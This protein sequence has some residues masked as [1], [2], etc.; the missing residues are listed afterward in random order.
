MGQGV[1]SVEAYRPW[2]L[3]LFPAPVHETPI[4]PEGRYRI[5][6]GVPYL[7]YEVTGAWCTLIHCHGNATDCEHV[8]AKCRALAGQLGVNVVSWEYP[9]YGCRAGETPTAERMRQDAVAVY[10]HLVDHLG[11][12]PQHILVLGH[13]IGS[14]PAV[15]LA[16]SRPS[17]GGLILISPYTSIAA[18]VAHKLGWPWAYVLP[19]IFDNARHAAQVSCPV[20]L[21][22]G[23]AD[24]LIPSHHSETLATLFVR[25]ELRVVEDATHNAWHWTRDIIVPV[26]K[27]LQTLYKDI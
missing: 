2:R 16:A 14:G 22:H 5:A 18:I 17:L 24:T 23:G 12:L 3:F 27:W 19:P 11:L 10:D 25:P 26:R 8:Q 15:Y 6:H 4:T 13:S 7:Y 9:G 21:L 20:L 1:F